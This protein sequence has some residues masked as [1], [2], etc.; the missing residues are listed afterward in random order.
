MINKRKKRKSN[1]N[2]SW[3]HQRLDPKQAKLKEVLSKQE[4]FNEAVRLCL[5]LHGLVHSGNV[6]AQKKP[7]LLDTLFD[8]L[9]KEAV[10]LLC[11]SNAAMPAAKGVTI[12]WNIWHITR[13]KILPLIS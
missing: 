13:M 10:D 5:E 1:K 9:P 2:V 12:A 7:T 11:K 6:M 4:H 3:S 8:G